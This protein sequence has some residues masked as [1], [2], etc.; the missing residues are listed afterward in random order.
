MDAAFDRFRRR[1]V[2]DPELRARLLAEDDP[3][4]FAVRVV[5]LAHVEGIDI[6]L[7]TVRTE[8]DA[9]RHRWLARWV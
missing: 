1:V 5:A 8:M 4:R 6:G 7:D 9:A 3:Q 2:A